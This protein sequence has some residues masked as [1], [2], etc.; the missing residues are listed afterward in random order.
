MAARVPR[1]LNLNG[2]GEWFLDCGG[3]GGCTSAQPFKSE[4]RIFGEFEKKRSLTRGRTMCARVPA[5][6]QEMSFEFDARSKN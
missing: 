1:F 2:S 6:I 3:E 5:I 4:V